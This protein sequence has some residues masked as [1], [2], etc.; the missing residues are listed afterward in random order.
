MRYSI[1]RQSGSKDRPK[2]KGLK[3]EDLQNSSGKKSN[4]K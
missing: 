3:M 4:S 1:S 2:R